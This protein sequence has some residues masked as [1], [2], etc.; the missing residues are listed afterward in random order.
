MAQLLGEVLKSVQDLN[1]PDAHPTNGHVSSMA[2][3]RLGVVFTVFAQLLCQA[4]SL[5]AEQAG[6]AAALRPGTSS[7]EIIAAIGPP[8]NDRPINRADPIKD[9]CASDDR[10][11]RAFEYEVPSEG[12]LRRTLTAIGQFEISSITTVCLDKDQKVTSTHVTQF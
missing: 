12:L 4:C 6:R 9:P 7:A 2:I 3:R 10:S 5:G 8:A 11:F 1:C